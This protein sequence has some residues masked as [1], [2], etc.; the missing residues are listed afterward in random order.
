MIIERM[1]GASRKNMRIFRQLCGDANLQSV[2]L[3]TTMWKASTNES[4][5]REFED[6]QEQLRLNPEFWG[7]M[8]SHGSPVL[9]HD[10]TVDSALAIIRYILGQNR[11][12]TLQVQRE[13]MEDGKRLDETLAGQEL[14][15]ELLEQRR[16]FEKRLQDAREEMKQAIDEGNKRAIQEAAE[17]QEKFQK[18]LDLAM[19]G[20][21]ELKISME[22]IVEQKESE[23]QKAQ[24][25]L[26]ALQKLKAAQEKPSTSGSTG[27]PTKFTFRKAFKEGAGSSLGKWVT[28]A[29]VAGVGGGAAAATL[30]NVM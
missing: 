12:T 28:G 21:E 5:R 9:R 27:N 26:D 4:M 30:C 13:M 29:G 3:A 1:T 22:K 11:R 19:K 17:Q 8:A 20:S 2:V 10:D 23:R 16:L 15:R 7:E 24:E 18:Q 14:S 6:R 25:A